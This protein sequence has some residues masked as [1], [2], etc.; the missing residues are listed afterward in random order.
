MLNLTDQMEKAVFSMP[1]AQ[2]MVDLILHT[3][4]AKDVAST[5]AVWL[6]CHCTKQGGLPCRHVQLEQL[7]LWTMTEQIILQHLLYHTQDERMVDTIFQV[8]CLK[9]SF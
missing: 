8:K 1:M 3:Q 9:N 6:L 2:A 4:S 7:L 5:Q